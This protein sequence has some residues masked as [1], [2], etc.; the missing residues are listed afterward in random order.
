MGAWSG[1]LFGLVQDLIPDDGAVDGLALAYADEQRL[2]DA[3]GNVKQLILQMQVG[4][5]RHLS[6]A[7]WRLL[8]N[9]SCNPQDAHGHSPMLMLLQVYYAKSCYAPVSEMTSGMLKYVFDMTTT[10]TSLQLFVSSGTS[11]ALM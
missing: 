11:G 5:M 2:T 3:D 7:R 8:S 10:A 9:L 4:S 1:Q 6:A